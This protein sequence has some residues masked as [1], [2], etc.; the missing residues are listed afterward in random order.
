[1]P[2][3]YAYP[4]PA[5]T[6]DALVLSLKRDRVLL[7]KRGKPPFEGQWALPGG[8]VGMEETLEEAVIRELFEETQLSGVELKQFHAFSA[9]DRDPRHRTISV[10]YTGTADHEGAQTG[11]GD[12][13]SDVRWFRTADLPR[14]A[15]DHKEIIEMALNKLK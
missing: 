3:T 10:V 5:I 2:F 12:D 14:L 13:A 1:M 7:I 15:F 6:V 9:V 8:F 4:R 11:A